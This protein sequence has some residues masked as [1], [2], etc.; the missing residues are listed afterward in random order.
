MTDTVATPPSLGTPSVTTWTRLEPR[1]ASED[2]R[3]GVAARV[4]DA[5][6]LLCRQWQLGEFTG[7]D[8]GSPISARLRLKAGALT[9]YRGLALPDD[10]GTPYDSAAMPLETLV[11]REGDDG[12]DLSVYADGGRLFLRLLDRAGLGAYRS[13][14][15]EYYPLPQPPSGP[16]LDEA[17]QRRLALLRGR[18]PDAR[19]LATAFA[20]GDLPGTPE[21]AA[22]DRPAMRSVIAEFLRRWPALVSRADAGPAW[23]RHRMEHRFALGARVGEEEVTLVAAEYPGGSLDWPD[24]EVGTDAVPTGPARPD[25]VRTG[26]PTQVRYPGMPVDRWWEFEES[27]VSFVGAEA[28]A[29][30]LARLLMLEFATLFSNDWFVMPVEL[31]VGTVARVG[32]LVVTDT[33]GIRTRIGP[34][35]D[36]GWRMYTVDDLFVLPPALPDS[37]DGQPI[38]DVVLLRDENANVVW[39]VERTVPSP[40]GRPVDRHEQHLATLRGEPAP[41]PPDAPPADLHYRLRSARPPVHWIPML[42]EHNENGLRLRR[43]ALSTPDGWA[44]P[45]AGR[46][47]TDTDWLHAEE[48]PREGSQII[49]SWQRARWSDGSTHLWLSRRKLP[50]RGEASSDLRHDILDRN[51]RNPD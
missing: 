47:L 30:D 20:G 26:L 44:P 15:A 48:V 1:L 50:S 12:A 16:A 38:E 42:P 3:E 34:A 43:S 49:R 8:G 45:P 51:P 35:A 4:E 11:E 32:S 29:P 41:P 17:A 18:V 28:G 7:S 19:V 36:T 31:P 13:A 39:A 2:L 33:F 37:M 24:L 40:T 6:W 9:G 5:A 27:S 23:D 46:L 25:L 14:F 10:A 22:A 21:I